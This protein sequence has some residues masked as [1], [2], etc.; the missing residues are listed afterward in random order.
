MRCRTAIEAALLDQQLGQD[1]NDVEHR[2]PDVIE[3]GLVPY[4]EQCFGHLLARVSD[5]LCKG[6][7]PRF[8]ARH[9]EQIR[10][11]RNR[12]V[13]LDEA[14]ME[15]DTA[16]TEAR[17]QGNADPTF[18]YRVWWASY[19]VLSGF[20]YVN[21]EV[22]PWATRSDKGDDDDCLRSGRCSELR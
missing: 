14:N 21:S 8:V 11:M 2:V 20:Q 19:G 18:H 17:A 15:A 9:H 10:G 12:G 3:I 22:P 1:S 7:R 16:N 6:C 4:C 13:E 5:A